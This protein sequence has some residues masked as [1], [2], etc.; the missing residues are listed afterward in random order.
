M[1][2]QE[3]IKYISD[4]LGAEKKRLKLLITNGDIPAAW[5]GHELSAYISDQA[6]NNASRSVINRHPR[7]KRARAYRNA[8][9]ISARLL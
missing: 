9:T 8:I 6:V 1:T 7:G 3:K 5:D 4:L 2:K